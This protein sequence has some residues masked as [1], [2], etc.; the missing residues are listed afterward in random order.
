MLVTDTGISR[1]RWVAGSLQESKLD[2]VVSNDDR[3]TLEKEFSILSD[4]YLLKMCCLRYRNVIRERI[5]ITTRNWNFDR[6]KARTILT[7]YLFTLPIMS[8]TTV[9]EID[10]K[11]NLCVD[12][13]RFI[14]FVDP[15]FLDPFS[16]HVKWFF[17]NLPLS[18]FHSFTFL[19]IPLVIQNL[20]IDATLPVAFVTCHMFTCSTFYFIWNILLLEYSCIVYILI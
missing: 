11:V 3:F 18:P 7:N 8:G 14:R 12:L 15:T 1:A 5:K 20:L 13:I 2:F 6:E 16:L 19:H 10:Y 17:Q 9:E 4:H